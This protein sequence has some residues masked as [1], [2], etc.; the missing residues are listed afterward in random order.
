MLIKSTKAVVERTFTNDP[1][2]I[3]FIK[4]KLPHNR[5]NKQ[6]GKDISSQKSAG[7]TPLAIAECKLC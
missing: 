6:P 4:E 5:V 2:I 1:F 7:V 3:W